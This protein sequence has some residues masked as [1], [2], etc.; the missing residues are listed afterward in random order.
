MKVSVILLGGGS[1]LRMG[2]AIPKQFLILGDKPIIQHSYD[3]FMSMPEIAEVIVV[4]L[5]EYH[6]HFTK[7]PGQP[8]LNFA[9]PGSRR[10]DSVENGLKAM[11]ENCPYV[12]IHDGVRPFINIPMIKRTL[13]A[14]VEYGAAAAGMPVKF[15]VK[16]CDPKCV[17]TRTPDRSAFWEIQ[18][19]QII[20]TDLLRQGFTFVN[21]HQKTVTDD[22]SLVEQIGQPVKL[23]EG[24][25]TNLKI[26]TPDDLA[27]SEQLLNA[28]K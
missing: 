8:L 11:Q 27:L 6:W 13:Q 5:Q 23:V 9:L 2:S 1:G 18:T 15:T 3:V 28:K 12:C 16:E 22:V 19:P 26:T 7:K 14:A 24:C 20:R 25:Y 4:A 10:Q 17:V 21:A